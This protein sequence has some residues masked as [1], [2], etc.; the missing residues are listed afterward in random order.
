MLTKWAYIIGSGQGANLF[1]VKFDEG[2]DHHPTPKLWFLTSKMALSAPH[3][4]Y[5]GG[6]HLAMKTPNVGVGRVLI[7]LEHSENMVLMCGGGKSFYLFVVSSSWSC[8]FLK[9]PDCSHVLGNSDVQVL[10]RLQCYA[11]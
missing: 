11:A 8:Y 9:R 2:M 10:I 1:R 7:F 4:E 5:F 6:R 3:G